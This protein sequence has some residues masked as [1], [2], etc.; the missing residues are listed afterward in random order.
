MGM[1]YVPKAG[2]ETT[3]RGAVG[4]LQDKPQLWELADV[5]HRRALSTSADDRV[6]TGDTSE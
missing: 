4:G 3:H 5:K 6:N 1:T 2:P